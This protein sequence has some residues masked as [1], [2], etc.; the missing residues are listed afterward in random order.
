MRTAVGGEPAPDCVRDAARR[1]D[2]GTELCNAAAIDRRQRR[3]R[4]LLADVSQG[5]SDRRAANER[6]RALTRLIERLSRASVT[7]VL[8]G[9]RNR[10]GFLRDGSLLLST[11]AVR[12][13]F[14]TVFFFDVDR[15]KEV[16]DVSGHAA[17]DVLLRRAAHALDA[18]FRAGDV[19]GRLGGDEF[20]AISVT[21]R[22]EEVPVILTRLARNLDRVNEAGGEWPVELSAGVAIAAPGDSLS[23][24]RLLDR[25]DR[26]MYQHKRARG[27]GQFRLLAG[28]GAGSG[29]PQA[30]V[31]HSRR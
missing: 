26:L 28:A 19:T 15:L 22:E 21:R 6:I 1:I 31:G 12:P 24:A 13:R 7:D 9:L 18:T 29:G 27:S 23:L 4:E 10:Q 14:A 5:R 25:A 17:G 2:W 30:R 3:L 16:N 20:A 11:A 8:T